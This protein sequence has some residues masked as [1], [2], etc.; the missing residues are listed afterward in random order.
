MNR[1]SGWCGVFAGGDFEEGSGALVLKEA[2][3]IICL[4]P[5][6]LFFF[7]SALFTHYN[8]GMNDGERR[9]SIVFWTCGGLSTWVSNGMRTN[10]ARREM[11]KRAGINSKPPDG[12]AAFKE[13]L[14]RFPRE[15]QHQ[16]DSNSDS[17]LTPVESDDDVPILSQP[18]HASEDDPGSDLTE[19]ES[20][21]ERE[22]V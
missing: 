12:K 6:D 15:P 21:S 2:K 5:G 17:Y 19:V 14:K 10:I 18:L 9:Y 8:L 4:R 11:E 3:V 22:D 13:D 20:E 1:A 16:D 7:P